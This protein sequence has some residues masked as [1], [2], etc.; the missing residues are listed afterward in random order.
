MYVTREI[1]YIAVPGLG[2]QILSIKKKVSIKDSLVFLMQDFISAPKVLSSYILC[3][4][5]VEVAQTRA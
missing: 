1:I 4:I 3:E 5:H 2:L